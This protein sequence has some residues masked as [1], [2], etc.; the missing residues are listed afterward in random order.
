M[1]SLKPP[2]SPTVACDAPVEREEETRDDSDPWRVGWCLDEHRRPDILG[3]S[4][5]VNSWVNGA[6]E[7]KG[8]EHA[9]VLREVQFVKW[10]MGGVFRPRTDEAD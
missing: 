7:V 9:E 10:C 1:L 3:D 4:G 6:W 8:H 2:E 5:F